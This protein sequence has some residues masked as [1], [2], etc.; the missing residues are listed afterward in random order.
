MPH[1]RSTSKLPIILRPLLTNRDTDLLS[2]LF[3]PA[4]HYIA[5]NSFHFLE[6]EMYSIQSSEL[7]LGQNFG[8]GHMKSKEIKFRHRRK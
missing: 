6:G 1:S 8:P 4:T 2:Y 7:G 3:L 5:N